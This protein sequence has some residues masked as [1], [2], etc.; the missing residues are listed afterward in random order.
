VVT[1]V[2]TVTLSL[3]WAILLGL[4]TAWLSRRLARPREGN[5]KK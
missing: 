3:E 2:G 1:F 4:A 5:C